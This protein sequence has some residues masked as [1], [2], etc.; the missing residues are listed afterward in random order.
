[1]ALTMMV[2]LIGLSQ[3]TKG[4]R[5]F[6]DRTQYFSLKKAIRNADRATSL[7]IKYDPMP[8]L[9]PRIGKLQKLKYLQ[10]SDCKVQSIPDELKELGS[11]EYLLFQTNPKLDHKKVVDL[12]SNF[13]H[14]KMLVLS[15]CNIYELSD[16]IYKLDSITKLG[17]SF[18]QLTDL[19][20]AIGQLSQL[21]TL[22]LRRNHIHRLPESMGNL[23]RLTEIDLSYNKLIEWDQVGAVLESLQ[24][25]KELGL[26][27][28]DI[29]EIPEFLE[30]MTHLEKLHLGG[31]QIPKADII[32]LQL[33]L[34]GVEIS[35]D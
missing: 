1:M 31:N 26:Y 29:A 27:N 17:L 14:L 15:G 33:K 28:C 35:S 7:Q 18:N 21:C 34:E 11:L 5:L 25:L 24:G 30:R 22:N 8:V 16:S 10:I 20:A 2:L 4:Q 12:C 6:S 13:P 32:A 23:L 19:P 9:T 3:N